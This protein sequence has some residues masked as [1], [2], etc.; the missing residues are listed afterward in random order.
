MSYC[1]AYM[2]ENK[3]VAFCLLDIEVVRLRI[4]GNIYNPGDAFTTETIFDMHTDDADLFRRAVLAA[5]KSLKET[6]KEW[7]INEIRRDLENIEELKAERTIAWNKNDRESYDC[8]TGQIR[9]LNIGI[10]CQG[11]LD[12]YLAGEKVFVLRDREAGNIIDRFAT[13]REAQNTLEDY[14]AA[15][16]KD[17]TY[18]PDFYEI[19]VMGEDNDQ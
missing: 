7:A 13:M 17:G 6:V 14:E 10:S 12:S 1:T 5:G 9:E 4:D 15:D 18:T 3:R 19:V 8:I 16:K 2:S 11:L